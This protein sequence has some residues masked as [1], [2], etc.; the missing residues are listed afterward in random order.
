MKV[1]K[2]AKK[3]L[4]AIAALLAISAILVSPTV[5][6]AAV[7]PALILTIP[8]IPAK[9]KIEDIEIPERVRVGDKLLVRVRM[10]TIGFGIVKVMHKLPEPFEIV[11]GVN[12]TS[13]A[14]FGFARLKIEYECTPLKKGVYSMGNLVVESENLMATGNAAKEIDAGRLLEVR[15][16]VYRVRRVDLKRG[17]AK[18]PIPEIDIAQIGS[19]GT[20]FREIRKYVSGD[21]LRFVN[22]KATARIG[23]MMVNEFER[24]GRKAIWIF[25][26]ANKYMKHGTVL[27]NC[28]DV[29]SEIAIS[30]CYFFAVRGYNVGMYVLGHGIAFHPESG[31]RQFRKVLSALSEIEVSDAVENFIGAVEKAKRYMEVFKPASIFIT[32]V[33]RAVDLKKAAAK[34]MKSG[35]RH[36]DLPVTVITVRGFDDGESIASRI[37]EISRRREIAKL[38]KMGVGVVEVEADAKPEKIVP[39]VR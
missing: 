30:L 4:T 3:L 36:R 21:P 2:S 38:R 33:E 14:V 29:A 5:A 31:R 22:W 37:A 35:M 15:S 1:R 28:Y 19:P 32:R 39:I 13:S 9:I 16:R 8:T 6:I 10:K 34:A 24:E 11:S 17:I 12:A 18:K 27:R 7:L 20:D 23:E 25:L 26:D